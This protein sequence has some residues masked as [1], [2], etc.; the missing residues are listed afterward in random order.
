MDSKMSINH[1]DFLKDI[2]FKNENKVIDSSENTTEEIKVKKN[3][4]CNSCNKKT[5]L[6]G[7]ICKCQNNYCSAHRHAESHSCNFD[8]KSDG[9]KLLQQI[10]QK[11]IADKVNKI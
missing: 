6:T 3:N 4:R 8:Y 7:F 5:G 11:C 2:Y 1:I 9:F 10:N